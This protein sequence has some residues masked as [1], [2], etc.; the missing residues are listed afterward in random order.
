MRVDVRLLE[1][2]V[3]EASRIRLVKDVR[4]ANIASGEMCPG[5]GIGKGGI[6]EAIRGQKFGS[7][8]NAATSADLKDCRI[9]Q[10]HSRTNQG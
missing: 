4:E 8:G 10:I 2:G 6:D 7:A 5:F 1:R 3:S 9:K